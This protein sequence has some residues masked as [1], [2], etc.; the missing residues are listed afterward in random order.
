MLLCPGLELRGAAHGRYVCPKASRRLPQA[1]VLMTNHEMSSPH[2]LTLDYLMHQAPCLVSPS[3]GVLRLGLGSVEFLAEASRHRSVSCVL[4][5]G[6]FVC[7]VRLDG[8]PFRCTVDTGAGTTVSV[9]RTRAASLHAATATGPG[10]RQH[11]EQVGSA[12]RMPMRRRIS[13]APQ[14]RDE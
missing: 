8:V 13:A 11:T 10:G 14:P 5:G 3:R 4:H 9:S 6:A 1:D 7:E 12:L 2:I